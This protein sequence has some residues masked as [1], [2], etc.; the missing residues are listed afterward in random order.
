M[1]VILRQST[2]VDILIGPFVDE[3]DGKTLE[4]SLTISQGDVMLSKNGQALAQ[5]N[6]NTACAF[7]DFGC[8]NCELDATDT[9]TVGE[10]TVVVFEDGALPFRRDYMVVEEAVYDALFAGSAT[11]LLPANVTQWLGQAVAAVTVNGVPEVDVTHFGGSA[12]T[13]SSGRPEANVNAIANGA[14]T[15]NAVATGAFD[16]DALATDAAQEIADALLDR[17]AGVETGLT[18]RQWLRL[19]ASALFGKAS[20]AGSATIRYRDVGDTKDR[21]TASVDADGNRTAVTRDAT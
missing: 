4:E 11:G 9:N 17:S 7:D 10:L 2:A 16:A 13:F 1:A 12:G 14:I 15:A 3:D 6:D 21:I 18:V 5:K 8:Y 20:G 19:A